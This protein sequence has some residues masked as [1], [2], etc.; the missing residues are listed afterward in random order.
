M[1]DCILMNTDGKVVERTIISK[2]ILSISEG[3]DIQVKIL[4][5][6]Y[7]LDLYDKKK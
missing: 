1:Y 2:R 5:N 6:D 7:Y 4:N 3:K